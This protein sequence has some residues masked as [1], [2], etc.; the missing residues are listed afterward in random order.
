MNQESS[1]IISFLKSQYPRETRKQLVKSL[2]D[3]E[4]SKEIED[5]VRIEKIIDQIFSYVLKELGWNMASNAN[6][7]DATALEIM[8]ESFPKIE[9]SRWYKTRDFTPDKD[10]EVRMEDR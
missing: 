2:L 6:E 7:W 8:K 10:I 9:T 3:A 1:K 4:K 5:L